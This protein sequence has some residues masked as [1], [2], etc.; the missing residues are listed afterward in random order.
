MVTKRRPPGSGTTRQLPSGR[1]QA[2]FRGTDGVMRP[3]GVSFDT[4]LDATAW[5]NAQGAAVAR[6]G[7]AAPARQADSPS[8]LTLKDYADSWLAARQLK[9]LTRIHYR[10]LLDA[11]ILPELGAVAMASVTPTTIRGWHGTLN[12]NTPTLRAHAYGLLRTVFATAV[13]DDLVATN[14]C[15]VR[16]AGSAPTVHRPRVATLGEIDAIAG[17][18]APRFQAMVLL[19]AWCGLRFGE[20]TE[21]RRGDVDLEAQLV[22]VE[23]GVTSR[24]GQKFIGSPKSQAGRRSVAVPPHLVP[25]LAEHLAEHVGPGPGALLFP[26][27]HGGSLALSTFNKAYHPARAEAGRPDLRLHDL[28][29]TGATLAAATGAT[30]ADLMGRLGH[31]T[32]AAAL[33]YQHA[34]ADRDQAIAAALSVF[35]K[36]NVIPLR[37]VP[38]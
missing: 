10:E 36:D 18:I 20:L 23:R 19:A 6:G 38:R 15:R 27:K 4:K 28:R 13:A 30:L 24:G 32:P 25:R 1:W 17:A 29:H 22:R 33:R 14:P 37:S 34:A 12:A 16:G 9:P 21:L 8:V 7:W 11:Q 31:S 35:A 2:R 5:C 3:A 26:A